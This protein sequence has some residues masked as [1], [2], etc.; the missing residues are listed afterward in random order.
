MKTL[1]VKYGKDQITNVQ[2]LG[3]LQNARLTPAMARRAA[4]IAAGHERGV[5]VIDGN[6]GYIIYSEK[7]NSHRKIAIDNGDACHNCGGTEILY[8][9]EP[10][11]IVSPAIQ[12]QCQDCRREWEV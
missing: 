2:L 10:G 1:T 7:R 8:R 11:N 3:E 5:T 6:I 4:R 9:D 12:A